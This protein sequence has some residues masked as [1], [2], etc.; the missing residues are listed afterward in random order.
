MG[1]KEKLLDQLLPLFPLKISTF[2]D[3][4]GGSG[5]VSLNVKANTYV[6]NDLSKHIYNL[7]EMFATIPSEDIINY[8]YEQR[9]K[10]GFSVSITDKKIIPVYN[11]EPYRKLRKDVNN[12]PTVL[13][14]Y[15]LSFYSFCNQFRFSK[16]NKFN[17]PVGN[18]YF[19]SEFIPCIRDFCDFF[20]NN[21]VRCYNKSY[22]E[23]QIDDVN[24]FVYLDIPYCNTN[25]VYNETSRDL[26]GWNETNDKKF[27]TYCEKLNALGVKWCISN[28]FTNKGKTNWHLI[29]WV[30]KFN[31]EVVH[32][33]MKYAS[34]GVDA[35]ET[36]E[37]AILNYCP[38]CFLF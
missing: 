7:Y 3:L 11:K 37:V 38:E 29:E 4:F 18:G 15:F 31:W 13:G 19:K 2:Y 6:L 24:G 12:N 26:G 8:C 33:N 22:E 27:F 28:V 10:Y 32:L 30:K 34:H 9:N 1:T 17:M 20:R 21:D 16:E 36:D 14:Y 35:N 23:V 5:V 25:A